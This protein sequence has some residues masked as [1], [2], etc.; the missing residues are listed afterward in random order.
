MRR[1][2]DELERLEARNIILSSNL[3]R[4]LDGQPRSNQQMP[5]DP[6][7]ACY[8]TRNK[9]PM[10]LACDAWIEPAGNIAA[11]AGHIECIRAMDRYGVGTLDRVFTG[12]AALPA[13]GTTANRPWWRVL[14]L[15]GPI[16]GDTALPHC[17]F[18]YRKLAKERHP[19]APTGSTYMM[20]ELNEAIAEA[21]RALA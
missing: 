19:D 15:D 1:L 11:I 13:P 14:G 8:F 18:L 10:V 21:R 7:V 3:E 9:Q 6:G 2:S 16:T 17:E 5:D 20:A 12:Y 4:R